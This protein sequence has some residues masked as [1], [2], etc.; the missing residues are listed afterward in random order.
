M[1]A[2][3]QRKLWNVVASGLTSGAGI[4][5]SVRTDTLEGNRRMKSRR[6]AGS[7]A[8]VLLA[9]SLASANSAVEQRCTDLGVYNASTNPNGACVGSETM[10]V[11]ENGGA[12]FSAMHNWSNSPS[13]SEFKLNDFSGTMQSVPIANAGARP[14]GNVVQYVTDLASTGFQMISAR[15]DRNF[16][17]PARE[18]LRWYV[19]HSTSIYGSNGSGCNHK[20]L[21]MKNGGFALEEQDRS[22]TSGGPYGPLVFYSDHGETQTCTAGALCAD[23][24]LAGAGYLSPS[25]SPSDCMNNWCRVEV[26][27]T[28]R[29]VPG[30]D[31]TQANKGPYWGEVYVKPLDGRP[32]GSGRVWLGLNGFL[33][34]GHIG[35]ELNNDIQQGSASY[36]I[37]YVMQAGWNTDSG[38]RI[39]AATEF[40]GGGTGTTSP[41]PTVTAPAPPVLLP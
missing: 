37:S 20:L 22:C 23:S 34:D 9:A 4:R 16:S 10:D 28:T 1:S 39:G 41:A 26:C 6:F 33:S 12:P 25:Y 19:K 40:E 24:V 11:N 36:W 15:T 35:I 27:A 14:S 7:A 32:E 13:S 8:V 17:K 30:A 29:N 2:A 21:F 18:C 38:Q 5:V 3:N 31:L